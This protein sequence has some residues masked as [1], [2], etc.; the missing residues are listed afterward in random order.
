MRGCGWNGTGH[1]LDPCGIPS[2]ISKVMVTTNSLLQNVYSSSYNKQLRPTHSICMRPIRPHLVRGDKIENPGV[3]EA[4]SLVR[5]CNR[6]RVR[7]DTSSTSR[8]T[9]AMTAVFGRV[10]VTGF[11]PSGPWQN[12]I[13][14]V[15]LWCSESASGGMGVAFEV[16]VWR[17]LRTNT[18]D[19]F[20]FSKEPFR[21]SSRSTVGIRPI[22]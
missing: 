12:N 10:S 13:K 15:L 9:F 8:S 6:N 1:R 4:A 21:P 18:G 7:R 14:L 19:R 5:S 2:T 3:Q 17:L 20:K 11:L 16:E 22:L